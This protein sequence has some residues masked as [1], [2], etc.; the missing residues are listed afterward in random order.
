[1]IQRIQTLWLLAAVAAVA[2]SFA[3]P[4]LQAPDGDPA[5]TVSALADG[6]LTPTDNP[7]L[8]GL[9]VLGAITALAA[10]FLFKN[11]PLQGRLAMAGAGIG[12]LLLGL[13][14]LA[15]NMARAEM[16]QQAKGSIGVGIALPA[17]YGL[18]CWLAARAIRRDEALV[19]SMD[20]LR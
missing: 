11:R 4:F 16:P 9:S 7:G 20:R 6:T 8:L 1:M 18:F 17:L 2:A 19:R 13:A 10:I 15:I 5:R 3:L 14:I 12:V